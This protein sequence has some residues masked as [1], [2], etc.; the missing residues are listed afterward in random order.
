MAENCDMRVTKASRGGA[1]SGKSPKSLPKS[2]TGLT[3][4]CESDEK[5][6]T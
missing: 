1:Q 3:D 2:E 6:N 5:N 4:V